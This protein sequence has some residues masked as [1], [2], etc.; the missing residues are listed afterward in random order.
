[1]GA[2]AP[3]Q[4]TAPS[5]PDH[6]HEVIQRGNRGMGFLAANT[7][8]HFRLFEDGGIIEV[9]ASDPNDEKSRAEIRAHLAHIATLF[10]QADFNIPMFIHDTTPPGVVTMAKLRAEIHYQYEERPGGGAVRIVTRSQSA[11]DAV[12]AFLLFQIV[13]HQTGD[14]AIVAPARR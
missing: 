12:H 1:V 5:D 9:A 4:N 14:S 2:A 6:G 10:S 8:H 7:A 13:E 3:Q 11:L